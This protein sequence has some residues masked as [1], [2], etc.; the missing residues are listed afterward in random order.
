VIEAA[1]IKEIVACLQDG[2]MQWIMWADSWRRDLAYGNGQP[3]IHP[4]HAGV[5]ARFDKALTDLG[6]P[7]ENSPAEP[8]PVG[9][10]ASSTNDE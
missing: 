2:R 6:H 4:T 8:P 5:I 3:E 1:Q 9:S 10:G 7:P